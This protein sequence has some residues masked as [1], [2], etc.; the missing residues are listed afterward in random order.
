[1]SA[2]DG[3]ESRWA[4]PFPGGSLSQGAPLFLGEGLCPQGDQSPP[5]L[6]WTWGFEEKQEE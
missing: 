1:M 6:R 4:R 5:D 3:P 2:V